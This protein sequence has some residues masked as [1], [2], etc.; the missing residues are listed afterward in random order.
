MYY[1]GYDCHHLISALPL[2]RSIFCFLRRVLTA[3][4]NHARYL[5]HDVKKKRVI[6][7]LHTIVPA[8]IL[9]VKS[10]QLFWMFSWVLQTT[11]ASRDTLVEC[12]EDRQAPHTRGLANKVI[13]T[14]APHPGWDKST[15]GWGNWDTDHITIDP[16]NSSARML[17]SFIGVRLRSWHPE[18]QSSGHF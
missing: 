18:A 11:T 16:Y 1:D 2:Y 15:G 9:V 7:I 8:L 6:C 13:P 5:W 4:V 14:L 3:L 17:F 10:L 12:V